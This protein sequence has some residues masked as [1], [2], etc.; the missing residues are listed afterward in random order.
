MIDGFIFDVYPDY[1]K[2]VMAI[3]FCTSKGVTKREQSYHPSFFVRT[4]QSERKRIARMLHDLPQVDQVI[5]TTAKIQ[6]GSEKEKPVLQVTPTR[7]QLLHHLAQMID[8]WGK[9]HR[10]Q[11]FN[12]DVRLP[13]RFLQERNLFFNAYVSNDNGRFILMDD[14]WAVDYAHPP[15]KMIDLEINTNN[16]HHFI[17]YEEPIKS[18]DIGKKRIEEKNEVDTILNSLHY[19]NKLDP[20]IILSKKG[21]SIFFPLLLHRA[22]KHHINQKLFLGRDQT[23]LAA[24]KKDQSYMSYGRILYRPAFYTLKGRMHIDQ[25]HSF[26][27]REAG[28]YGL[29]DVSRCANI[30]AQLLSRLGAGTAIS[31]MQVNRAMQQG[32]L[33]PWKKNQPE[34]WKTVGR[35]LC[36]DRGGMIL[37]PMVGLHEKVIEL[38]YASLY[39]NIMV[40]QNISPETISCKCCPSSN[41]RVPQIGYHICTRKQGLIPQVLEPVLNRR[42]LFK[43]RS[44]NKCFDSKQYQGLQQAWKWV[45]L[46]CFGYTGYRNARYGRIECHESITAFSRHLLLAAMHLVEQAGYEV[47]HGIVDS[48]WIKEKNPQVK[49]F[50][51][52]RQISKKTGIR[53]DVEGRYHWIVFLPSK[54][55]GLGALNRYY[56]LFEDKTMKARGIELRQHNTPSFFALMQQDILQVFAEAE[57]AKEF[58]QLIPKALAV[59]KKYAF[60]LMQNKV[61]ASDLL[62]T[63]IISKQY[64]QYKVNT[65]PKAAFFQLKKMN[66]TVHPGQSVKY[67]IQHNETSNLSQKV[68]IA[69]QLSEDT[70]VDTIWYLR[71][72]CRCVESL[73]LP[74]GYDQDTI[75]QWILSRMEKRI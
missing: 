21:D 28:W 45:L 65:A 26:F 60:D 31:Q 16:K 10:Y 27:Y 34:D 8:S 48:L 63:T 40:Q 33:I 73:L 19:I 15:L 68:C 61:K 42:F 36:T 67:C 64:G 13:T 66:I 1:N 72:L 25:M 70:L 53:L 62:F 56:G 75:Y 69:E 2:D 35:L 50:L 3:W 7:L 57:N 12:V 44:K 11:L 22:Q 59:A 5:D 37:D 43:A 46:V 47:L 74:F 30:S 55:T 41:R 58:R 52:S 4:D 49:P 54:T 9:F 18:I 23:V 24:K 29:F 51:L 20:D 39:P 14:Q 71:Y 6:L 17:S 38:D 32:Y